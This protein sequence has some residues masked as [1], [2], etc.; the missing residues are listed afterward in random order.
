MSIFLS[1]SMI[2]KPFSENHKMVPESDC[3]LENFREHLLGLVLHLKGF[4]YMQ[5]GWTLKKM[6]E[7]VIIRNVSISISNISEPAF[8][9]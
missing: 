3:D 1:A 4:S 8:Y 5:K 2:L 7:K 6:T 9:T